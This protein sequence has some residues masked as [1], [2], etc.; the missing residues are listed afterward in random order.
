MQNTGT[1]E[2]LERGRALRW[3][4]LTG[5]VAAINTALRLGES[6]SA[7]PVASVSAGYKPAAL[8]VGGGSG[9][10][11]A[12][13]AGPTA[14]GDA[15]IV[16]AS[17]LHLAAKG[18]QVDAFS[19]LVSL[20]ARLDEPGTSIASIRSLVRLV[21][22]GPDATALLRVFLGNG[23]HLA[24]QLGQEIRDE[25]LLALLQACTPSRSPLAPSLEEYVGFAR[26]LLDAGASPDFLQGTHFRS[27]STLSTAVDTL[28]PDLIRLLLD[29]GAC[30][31]G[32][33][34]LKRPPL[35][36]WPLHNP[37]CAVTHALAMS[38]LDP[39]AQATLRKI[40]GMLLDSGANIN[41]CVPYIVV[42]RDWE[43]S[44]IS[45][46]LV[47]LDAVPCWDDE[48]GGPQALD[49]LRFLLG[50]GASPES[51]PPYPT[52]ES[53]L[54]H[55]TRSALVRSGRYWLGQPRLDPI[56][57]LLEAW[58]VGR[59]ASPAFASAL[60]LL[61]GHPSRRGGVREVAD[62][63]ARH[64]YCTVPHASLSSS[65]PPDTDTT[66]QDDDAV[67]AA[68]GRII[69]STASLLNSDDLGEFL[70][71][72]I[73]RKGTCPR[74]PRWR[75]GPHHRSAEDEIGD[76]AMTTVTVLLVAG[77]DINHRHHWLAPSGRSEE[78]R[79]GDGGSGYGDDA[80]ALHAI[81]LWLAGRASEEYGEIGGWRPSC[82][83]LRHTPRRARF[84]RTLVERFGADRGARYY[85]WT[86]AEMLVQMRRPELDAEEINKQWSSDADVVREARQALVALL[87]DGSNVPSCP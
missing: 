82:C 54:S 31:D 84:I 80:T 60:E 43:V 27:T 13:G 17:T 35:S 65:S 68:W 47:F 56:R 62:A 51:P 16:K 53:G 40:A 57:D 48:G 79:W 42:E 19:H 61:V 69:S 39:P 55:I 3:A 67:L 11:E 49:T 26:A 75:S 2:V 76:L 85:G 37:L 52:P 29:Y 64:E 25:A 4:C 77:A 72:Y 18:R 8:V 28:S 21:T 32:P 50:R 66:T 41:I 74:Q 7:V 46:L 83:G 45:P 5:C 86:P 58:G 24:R 70:H 1:Q 10:N 34:V 6:I 12:N 30:P 33:P 23:A 20:G 63:L 38:L 73:V 78:I 36:R 87:E 81:C 14:T 59:L 9:S 44:F 15:V 22:Q 71:A